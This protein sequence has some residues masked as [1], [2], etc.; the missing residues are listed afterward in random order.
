MALQDAGLPQGPKLEDR[1][2]SRP[3]LSAS[4]RHRAQGQRLFS[5]AN[6]ALFRLSR[7]RLG[8]RLRGVPIGLLTTTGRRSGKSRTVP[9]VYLEDGARYL[10]VASNSGLDFPPRGTGTSE[11]TPMPTYAPG[12][13]AQASLPAS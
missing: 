1:P 7:G 4:T 13:V 2:Y 5:R 3:P 6:T 9:V 12:P 10:V 8:G 11:R